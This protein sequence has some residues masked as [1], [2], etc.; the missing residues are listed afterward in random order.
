[1]SIDGRDPMRRSRPASAGPRHALTRSGFGW[2]DA[3]VTGVVGPQRVGELQAGVAQIAGHLVPVRP[4][5]LMDPGGEVVERLDHLRLA[6]AAVAGD[7]VDA[8]AQQ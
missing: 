1:M 8:L 4:G 5:S 6:E 7:P 2:R 3:D